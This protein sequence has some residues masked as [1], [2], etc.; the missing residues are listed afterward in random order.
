MVDEPVEELVCNAAELSARPG[1]AYVRP[2]VDGREVPL[3][4]THDDEYER[5][6]FASARAASCRSDRSLS[7]GFAGTLNDKLRGWYRSRLQGRRR[8]RAHHRHQ[9]DAGHGLPALLPVCWDEPDFK[10][11]F[12]VT[13]VAP[14]DLLAI[15][16][17]PEIERE[18]R[19]DGRHAARFARPC[20]STYLVAFITVPSSPPRPA[21]S[22]TC[23]CGWST[24]PART[25]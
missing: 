13:I 12:A 25:T 4:W 9:P 17:G 20:R 1:H 8:A 2:G 19:S 11:V 14:G 16:N 18:V 23:R 24:C 22:A 3:S 21:T 6:S 15:S 5:V 7:I 10:A